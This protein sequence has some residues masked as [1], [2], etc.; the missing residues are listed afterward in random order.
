MIIAAP[1]K[2]QETANNN[3]RVEV[4]LHSLPSLPGPPQSAPPK[5]THVRRR[6]PVRFIVSLSLLLIIALGLHSA[7][8][9]RFDDGPRPSHGRTFLAR[10]P[11][12]RHKHTP[13][14]P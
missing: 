1:D 12:N 14:S 5:A 10:P 2:S 3:E 7:R 6:R 11:H 13:F 8:R 4:P 9:G